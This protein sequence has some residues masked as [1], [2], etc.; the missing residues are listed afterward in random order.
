MSKVLLKKHIVLKGIITAKT[1]LRIGGSSERVE[2]GGVDN[3]IIKDKTTGKP[4]I[5]GSSIK[6][7]LRSLLEYESGKIHNNGGP[8]EWSDCQNTQDHILRIFGVSGNAG[9][10][11]NVGPG[12]LI[13]RDATLHG[14]FKDRPLDELVEIKTENMI[15]RLSGTALNPR[16]AER[17][18]AGVQF[19]FEL[20]YRV[21][22]VGDDDGQYDLNLFKQYIPRAL[23]LLEM[24]CLGGYGSRGYGKVEIVG[25]EIHDVSENGDKK[26]GEFKDIKELKEKIRTLI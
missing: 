15:N 25:I 12:R 2:I 7:K 1:G 14:S 13:V 5:P 20:S 17:V 3:T 9:D 23:E 4:F 26:L 24:D 16:S 10:S 8:W 22:S 18:P 6:G 11:W 19:E 21:F